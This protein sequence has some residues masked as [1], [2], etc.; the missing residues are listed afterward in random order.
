MSTICRLSFFACQPIKTVPQGEGG[1][2]TVGGAMNIMALWLLACECDGSSNVCVQFLFYGEKCNNDKKQAEFTRYIT[3][4]T[5]S[6]H[7]INDEICSYGAAQTFRVWQ[8]VFHAVP[9]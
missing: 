5:H 6:I 2:G 3:K 4:N 7:S 1:C 8:L 9:G